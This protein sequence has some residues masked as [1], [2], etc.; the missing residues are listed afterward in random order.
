MGNL[1]V[2]RKRVDSMR[3]IDLSDEFSFGAYEK[4]PHIGT[5]VDAPAYVQ[6]G[7]KKIIEFELEAFLLDAA[8]LDLSHK[9]P[10]QAIDDE[11]LEAAEEA[12]GLAL[13]EGEAAILYTD[14]SRG[15]GR[16]RMPHVYLS[17]NG[18]EYLEFKRVGMV[19]IDAASID[20]SA[21]PNMPAHL[22][23]LGK[24]ILVLEGLCNLGEVDLSRFRLAAFPL[25]LN[26]STSPARTVAILE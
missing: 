3:I 20:N 21:L 11:D 13:R 6:K 9:K 2:V 19:G 16:R 23:L 10:G 15:S 18:A 7:R 22:T 4:D 14:L 5:H 12:A 24:E 17:Q 8:L 1:R 25:K 26:A